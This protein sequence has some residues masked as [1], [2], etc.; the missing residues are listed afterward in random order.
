[1]T[2]EHTAAACFVLI[3][4]IIWVSTFCIVNPSCFELRVCP[5][6][7][8]KG[9]VQNLDW[10]ARMGLDWQFALNSHQSNLIQ[11]IQSGFDPH[12]SI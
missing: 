5:T 2:S 4:S 6:T 12:S 10:I 9:C 8:I 3:L 1:M 11:P 7:P